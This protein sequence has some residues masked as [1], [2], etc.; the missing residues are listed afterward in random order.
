M[1]KRSS[2]TSMKSREWS[3]Q[4]ITKFKIDKKKIKPMKRIKVR[5]RG[6]VMLRFLRMKKGRM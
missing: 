6:R 1:L 5:K 2:M 3:R 4:M